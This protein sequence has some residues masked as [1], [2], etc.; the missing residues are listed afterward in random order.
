MPSFK[1]NPFTQ[2]L[3]FCHKK[4]VFGADHSE[5]FVVLATTV[6]IQSQNVADGRTD[7]R[8]MILLS[9]IKSYSCNISS[10]RAYVCLAKKNPTAFGNH[11]L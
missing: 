11:A 4:L 6:L 1:K 7:G 9:R 8:S 2:G 10:R 3:K 5:D